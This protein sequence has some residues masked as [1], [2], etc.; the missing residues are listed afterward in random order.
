MAEVPE[1]RRRGRPKGSKNRPK[2]TSADD[3]PNKPVDGGQELVDGREQ[4]EDEF[5]DEFDDEADEA[6][7]DPRYLAEVKDLEDRV[8][9]SID[10][11]WET[12]SLFEDVIEDLAEDKAFVDGEIRMVISCMISR[13]FSNDVDRSGGVYARGGRH[14][15]AAAAGHR[16]RG[17]LPADGG[18]R[19]DLGQEA[20][21]GIW[22]P[23]PG[24]PGWLR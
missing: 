14:V 2:V 3:S 6:D 20:A 7:E 18:R 22:D 21:D 10:S 5:D 16:T 11:V 1:K 9:D 13:Y 15:Q 12:E 8:Q 19:A 23:G 17:V 4:F 24:L